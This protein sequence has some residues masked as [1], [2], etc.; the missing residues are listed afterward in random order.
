MPAS[1]SARD[2]RSNK[3][4]P[5]GE[6]KLASPLVKREQR[7]SLHFTKGDESFFIKMDMMPTNFFFNHCFDKTRLKAFI[8]WS[9]SHN[10]PPKTLSIIEKMQ[11][12]GFSFATQAGISI[13]LD[14]LQLPPQK[15]RFLSRAE[16][17]VQST[18]RK[19]REGFVTDVERVDQVV[20]TW[21]RT[22]E[23]LRQDVV[24]HFQATD[25]L[26][27]VYMMAFSGARG[28]ISQVRQLTAMRGLMADPEG[29][30]IGFPIRSSFREGLTLTEY[31]ISCY[32]ARKGL[33][34]TA[35]RTADAGYLTRRLVDVSHHVIVNGNTCGT[36]QGIFLKEIQSERK[37][38]V[39]L[40]DR[41]VGRVL[42]ADI[43]FL[44][45]PSL[46]VSDFTEGDSPSVTRSRFTEGFASRANHPL[47][48]TKEN[49]KGVAYRSA[50]TEGVASDSRSERGASESPSVKRG[51]EQQG[52]GF[53]GKRNQIVSNGLA[54][55]LASHCQQVLVRSPLTCSLPSGVC[56]LCYGWNLGEQK[57]VSIGDAVGIIAA[58]SIG[59][60]G[61]QLT[62]RT[63][64]TGGVFTGHLVE[65][66]R[67]PH[68]GVISFPIPLQG[69]LIRTSSGR[70]AFLVK[71][72]G[73]CILKENCQKRD[74]FSPAPK[75]SLKVST[76][77]T[78]LSMEASTVL[79]VRQGEHVLQD[80]LL[81]QSPS[82]ETERNNTV[83]IR[84]IFA[85]LAGQVASTKSGREL[86][87]GR[88]K[89]SH[90]SRDL[91]KALWILAGSRL[92]LA[93]PEGI[94]RLMQ[95]QASFPRFT[96][97]L[98]SLASPKVMRITKGEASARFTRGDSL[99]ERPLLSS[100]STKISRFSLAQREARDQR[101]KKLV[102]FL[103][104]GR[105]IELLLDE[106]GTPQSKESLRRGKGVEVL[107]ATL[108]HLHREG[109][110]L[111]DGCSLLGEVLY[112]I[113][114]TTFLLERGYTTS[115]SAPTLEWRAYHPSPST[116]SK[117]LIRSRSEAR[118]LLALRETEGIT[119]QTEGD[120]FGEARLTRG[121]SLLF[122]KG[123]TSRFAR[124]RE[125]PLVK[126]EEERN[127]RT[128]QSEEKQFEGEI[129]RNQVTSKK[130]SFSP[131][132]TLSLYEQRAE[133]E[134]LAP[135]FN[136][137][138][139][140]RAREDAATFTAED[141]IS[142][143]TGGRKPIVSVGQFVSA[144]QEI[145]PNLGAPIGGQVIRVGRE[146][147]TL[148][149]AETILAYARGRFYAVK[150]EWVEGNTPI[151][152]LP[153]RQL[154]IDDIVQGI[155]KIEQLFEASKEK[156]G[157]PIKG[158]VQDRLKMFFQEYRSYLPLREAVSRSMEKIQ[159]ILVEGILKV[160]LSHGVV[161][162]DKHLEI[163]I[164]QM[165][166]KVEIKTPGK[167]GFFPGE[168]VNFDLVR[169]INRS[170]PSAAQRAKYEPA[171]FGITKT[172]L[173]SDS[174]LSA[175]SF[176]ETTRVLVRHASL[177]RIDYLRGL[178]QHVIVGDL[179]PAGT[180]LDLSSSSKVT[181]A[182]SETFGEA[183]EREKP[184]AR[185]SLSQ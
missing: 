100:P 62:M 82:L 115:P 177:G 128:G 122:T 162:A 13:G 151:V 74:L 86:H 163:I 18:A 57:L 58:Q 85:Q 66:V 166:S 47:L 76:N 60:P 31:M 53:L 116:K 83:E 77:E 168:Y 145:A 22:S 149:R 20:E 35:L 178:K 43:P 54:K 37:T 5:F 101:L 68:P 93:D 70:V 109:G 78:R 38:V 24:D 179:I 6:V 123:V 169:K 148:R 108:S 143:L 153:Y 103:P 39:P 92:P 59:E 104:E 7:D 89:R 170:L 94:K 126:R 75:V 64:H 33:V 56:Q 120:T 171:L 172:A 32:G 52:E 181:R 87:K 142:F 12:K 69:L 65:E 132:V 10:G 19:C 96:K 154:M 88:N 133:R 184:A 141:Q 79:F 159:E 45:S 130:L 72:E 161:I 112:K 4:F 113:R 110:H 28:N 158:G 73:E 147:V 114:S 185:P 131:K 119:S 97:G 67:A 90:S 118:P 124:K 98:A 121:D 40:E 150:G 46:K 183:R 173:N 176:Q 34:D 138:F 11:E 129:I 51:S 117:E 125:K 3:T 160:Y 144:G 139:A 99:R 102:Q 17:A 42:A 174:F 152:A 127:R 95:G 134:K 55:R 106:K 27:P 50:R 164:R 91:V 1:R 23:R 175:A 61:T 107:I 136:K 84:I 135:L 105:S 63:F 49:T 146:K 44:S 155:P 111:I 26:N 180:G 16:Y 30:I 182:R 15:T 14:D 71:V 137:G 41:L 8:L 157:V 2:L 36:R 156:R 48:F 9:Y 165:T 167:S 81:A 29:R 25:I 140:S 80:D 21:Q